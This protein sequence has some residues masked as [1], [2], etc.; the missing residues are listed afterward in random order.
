VLEVL[1]PV[2][3]LVLVKVKVTFGVVGNG[4]GA[5]DGISSLKQSRSW[6]W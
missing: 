2:L 3:V 1:T 6:I 5:L 4:V